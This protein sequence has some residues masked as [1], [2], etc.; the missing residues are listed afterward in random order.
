MSLDITI[1][2]EKENLIESI[3]IPY[4]SY[5]HI[6]EVIGKGQF[7][8]LKRLSDYYRDVEYKVE[9]LE[10]LHSEVKIIHAYF[11]DDKTTTNILPNILE[12]IG[13]AK[14]LGSKLFVLAD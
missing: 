11:S 13:K 14:R 3:E 6:M 10:S 1:L 9:E 5:I 8:L 7:P 12:L 2:D 4:S